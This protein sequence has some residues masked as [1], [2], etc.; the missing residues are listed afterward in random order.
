MLRNDAASFSSAS[1][2]DDVTAHQPPCPRRLC[3]PRSPAMRG[4]LPPW[5]CV[6][7]HL[8][9]QQ[10]PG[11]SER[12]REEARE[13]RHPLTEE[14]SPQEGTHWRVWGGHRDAEDS[15]SHTLWAEGGQRGQQW[16]QQRGRARVHSSLGAGGADGARGLRTPHPLP[17]SP[18]LD[19]LSA[20]LELAGR[21]H[22]RGQIQSSK[23]RRQR[24]ADLSPRGSV[25]G[26]L[27]SRH[28]FLLCAAFRGAPRPHHLCV[29]PLT[30][31]SEKGQDE[32]LNQAFQT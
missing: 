26:V 11:P 18:G 10:E 4:P 32:S 31:S 15:I 25:G 7:Y 28:G 14:G 1:G 19:P 17:G 27:C 12:G 2:K 23:P 24:H 8:V 20:G 3:L 5:W 21:I 9:E 30:L 16:A 22:N 29:F 6:S 13:R